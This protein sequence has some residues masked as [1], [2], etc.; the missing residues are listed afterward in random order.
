[1]KCVN[2][3]KD[4]V[5][6]NKFC[7]GCGAKV[8]T[9][10]AQ[11]NQG[12]YT[13][14]PQKN[15]TGLKV[16]AII[17]AVII[18]AGVGFGLWYFVFRDSNSNNENNAVENNNINTNTNTNTNTNNN[19]VPPVGDNKVTCSAKDDSGEVEVEEII[20]ATFTDDKVSN[21]K[22]E[23]HFEDEET[24]K[25]YYNFVQ[26]YDE[27]TE[28]DSKKVNAK[29]NGTIIIIENFENMLG[30]ETNE[31]DDEEP[32]DYVDVLSLNKEE[33]VKYM[34]ENGLICK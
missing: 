10:I 30:E 4:L 3:G 29:L 19:V 32:V 9:P 12:V 34:Q 21:L 2:C 13:P 11:E 22:A 1:M 16:I 15:Y 26:L 20:I 33:F 14:T 31:E 24:A 17:M 8:E 6:G 7:D 27:Y 28:D 23:M 25:Q 18:L 5:E